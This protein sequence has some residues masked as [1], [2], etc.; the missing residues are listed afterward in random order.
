MG[1]DIEMDS[2]QKHGDVFICFSGNHLRSPDAC[3]WRSLDYILIKATQ[4]C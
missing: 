2:C 1:H 3:R 4:S